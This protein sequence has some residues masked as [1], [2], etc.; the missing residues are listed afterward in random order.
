[1]SYPKIGCYPN[2]EAAVYQSD[3]WTS[4]VQ[5][6]WFQKVCVVDFKGVRA[7]YDPEGV[8]KRK[9]RHYMVPRWWGPPCFEAAEMCEK[10]HLLKKKHG[11]QL[12][13]SEKGMDVILRDQ[14]IKLLKAFMKY[15]EKGGFESSTVWIDG[16]KKKV[17]KPS[18]T[19]NI[20]NGKGGVKIPPL[21]FICWGCN[22]NFGSI[23]A[24]PAVMDV[25]LSFI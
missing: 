25:V 16:K 7:M 1:M 2:S 9:P 3:W 13:H 24:T 22:S 12:I 17:R 4:D 14:A 15:A 11:L 6:R 23:L 21:R 19:K 10:L 20:G 5:L 18:R 8:M